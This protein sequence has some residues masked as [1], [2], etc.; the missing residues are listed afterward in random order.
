MAVRV[1]KQATFDPEHPNRHSL[2]GG[3]GGGG[4]LVSK[5][6]KFLE[7]LGLDGASEPLSR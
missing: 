5:K 4:G 3:G 7:E 2:E 6:D 1:K